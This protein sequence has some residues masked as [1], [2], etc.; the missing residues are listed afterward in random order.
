L[1]DDWS[2][3]QR[4][5]SKSPRTIH[6]RRRVV[7]YFAKRYDALRASEGDLV[8]FLGELESRSKATRANYF[9]HL[10][11]WY[12]WLVFHGHRLDNPC[13]RLATPRFPRQ[14]PRPISNDE[15]ER[16][17]NSRLHRRARLHRRTRTMILLAAFQGL[18]VHE[19]AKISGEDVDVPAGTLRVV[20]KGSVDATL[21]LHPAIAEQAA[22]YPDHGYWFPGRNADEDHVLG[23]SVSGIIGEAMKRAGIA[24]GAHRLRH[25]YATSL[26]G[27]DVN[28][29][30]VQEL[31]RHA[32]LQTT[33]IYTQV[34]IDQQRTALRSLTLPVTNA[35]Q[36]APAS[37]LM[38]AVATVH[39][40]RSP[41][42]LRSLRTVD[43][44]P[45]P[46]RI[47]I[48]LYTSGLLWKDM[49]ALRWSDIVGD[50]VLT[51]GGVVQLPPAAV[52]A[53]DSEGKAEAPQ[54]NRRGTV[55]AVGRRLDVTPLVYVELLPRADSATTFD[56][57]WRE[58]T[59]SLI[60]DVVLSWMRTELSITSMPELARLLS[61]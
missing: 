6:E 61:E 43:A 48:W 47:A 44:A 38:P 28:L 46:V 54:R 5:E 51:A 2:A 59:G 49:A 31:M 24:P 30:V 18:R 12:R 13:D 35:E 36:T 4:A 56:Y 17:L 3:W 39:T 53:L 1:L 29:R 7:E 57:D 50:Q 58:A 9:G 40:S 27:A 26:V 15:L 25:W 21:P 20:G 55:I 52:C 34:T 45:A 42:N 22:L 23:H 37:P 14:R 32:S 60:N 8:A 10:R 16:L 19:I 11:A 41:G 33:Q